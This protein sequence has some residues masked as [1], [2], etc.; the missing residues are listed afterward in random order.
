[1]AEY[2]KVK[3]FEWNVYRNNY[4]KITG[5]KENE[6]DISFKKEM[7]K[8]LKNLPLRSLFLLSN[9]YMIKGKGLSDN[10]WS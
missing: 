1:M 6:I 8:L 9:F 2:M 5:F 10:R 4:I 7:M 3:G